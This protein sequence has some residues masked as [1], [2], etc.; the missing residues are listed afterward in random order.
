MK[1]RPRWI[2]RLPHCVYDCHCII[3][4]RLDGRS[5]ILDGW[6]KIG[7]CQP[8][9]RRMRSALWALSRRP[10]GRSELREVG[11]FD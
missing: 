6:G 11:Y 9:I 1:P 2:D 10:G 7:L 4:Y 3:D 5:C 8:E